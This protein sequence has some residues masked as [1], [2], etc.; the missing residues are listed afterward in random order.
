MSYAERWGEIHNTAILAFTGRNKVGVHELEEVVRET[1]PLLTSL[2]KLDA[3]DPS[4]KHDDEKAQAAKDFA[5]EL[6]K[7]YARASGA[8]HAVLDAAIAATDKDLHPEAYRQLKVLK[9]SLDHLTATI[10]SRARQYSKDVQKALEKANRKLVEGTEKAR[11]EGQTDDQVRDT[12]YLLKAKKALLM[13]PNAGKAA[14]AKAAVAIQK[15]KAKPD[16]ETYNKFMDSA[17]RDLSQQLNNILK[18]AADPN[19]GEDKITRRL[20]EE[21]RDLARWRARLAEFGNGDKRT[22]GDDESAQDILRL[23]KEFS[24]ML[25]AVTPIHEGILEVVKGIK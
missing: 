3:C 2:T 16:K 11:E 21:T 10:E 5:A 9:T 25:K 23:L 17:G 13:Y 12:V 15:I 6:K 19:A 7:G 4:L 20:I 14:I 8:Y 1:G 24:E 22:V 18:I